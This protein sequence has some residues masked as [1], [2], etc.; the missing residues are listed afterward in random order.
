MVSPQ[1]TPSSIKPTRVVNLIEQIE[2]THYQCLC[3]I[4][5]KCVVF[6]G[7]SL[8]PCNAGSSY[9]PTLQILYC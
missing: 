9:I 6:Y 5:I 7:I 8:K 1:L 2:G 3:A 4:L